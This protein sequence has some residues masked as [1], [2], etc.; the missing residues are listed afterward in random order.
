MLHSPRV[1][2]NRAPRAEGRQGSCSTRRGSADRR[3]FVIFIRR[4]FRF[5]FFKMKTLT[6]SPYRDPRPWKCGLCA[7]EGKTRQGLSGHM[8]LAHGGGLEHASASGSRTS[9]SGAWRGDAQISYFEKRR[10]LDH[11]LQRP[12]CVNLVQT[13]HMQPNAQTQPPRM[14]KVQPP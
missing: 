8:R 10:F 5:E 12:K 3:L 1:G 9:F 7:F 2:W 6:G 4:L 14:P 13:F 11:P